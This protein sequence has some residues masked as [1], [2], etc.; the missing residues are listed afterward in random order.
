ML[1]AS[2]SDETLTIVL[3]DVRASTLEEFLE[4]VF[5]ASDEDAIIDDSIKH[6]GF[7]IE[8]EDSHSEENVEEPNE[9]NKCQLVSES[10]G[11]IELDL[12]KAEPSI[13]PES[14]SILKRCDE[15]SSSC[16][17]KYLKFCKTI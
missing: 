3:P 7:G 13:E 15:L 2:D 5:L 14:C 10:I 8:G 1:C 6:L 12:C 16:E 9:E 4:R 11:I 17:K